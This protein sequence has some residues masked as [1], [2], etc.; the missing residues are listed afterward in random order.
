M[1]ASNDAMGAVAS[2]PRARRRVD[3]ARAQTRARGLERT[4][5]ACFAVFVDEALLDKAFGLTLSKRRFGSTFGA[6]ESWN[7]WFFGVAS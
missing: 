3:D 7:P 5:D 2:H 1:C 4:R 6:V